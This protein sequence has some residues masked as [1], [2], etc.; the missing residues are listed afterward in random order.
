MLLL[1]RL[2]RSKKIEYIHHPRF[3]VV[4]RLK[5][6]IFKSRH[7]IIHLDL[8]CTF[9]NEGCIIRLDAIMNCASVLDNY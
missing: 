8:L 7:K 5:G 3:S 1:C 9:V 6:F 2:V 4:I